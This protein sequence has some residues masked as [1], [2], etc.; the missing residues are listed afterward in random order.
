MAE[1]T[2]QILAEMATEQAGQ[3]ALSGLTST[4]A[5]AIY[6]LWKFVTASIIAFFDT[7]MD[8]FTADIQAIINSNQYGTDSWWYNK[9]LAYQYGDALVFLNNIFQYATV[10]A[11]KQI[12]VFSSVT[13]LNGVVQLKAATNNSGVPA[14]LTTPQYNGLLA[15]CQQCQPSGVR[16]ALLST[17][18][19]LLKFYGNIYYDPSGDITVIQPAVEAAINSFINSKNDNNFDGTL[20]L[21]KLVDAIQAVPNLTGNQVDV[22]SISSQNSGGQYADFTSSCQPESGYF[23]IDPAFPLSV[24]LNYIPYVSQ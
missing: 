22:L 14:P 2:D 23:I 15:Y 6:A 3:P 13:S 11:T 7:L 20:Y 10:D 19:D 5:T 12:I 24:T 21:N 16:F 1:T 9:L 4:S 8:L 18:P 17:N